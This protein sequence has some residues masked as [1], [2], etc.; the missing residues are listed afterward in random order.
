[1]GRGGDHVGMGGREVLFSSIVYFKS[2]LLK[3]HQLR[4]RREVT[5]PHYF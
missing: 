1:M 5:S 3:S 2:R 4:V